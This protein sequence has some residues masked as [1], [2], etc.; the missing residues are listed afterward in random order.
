MWTFWV[1]KENDQLKAYELASAHTIGL[2]CI[3]KSHKPAAVRF[4]VGAFIIRIGFWG[5]L[6]MIT[7]QYTPPPA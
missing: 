7:V 4:N 1:T 5:F 3:S 6:I 2:R